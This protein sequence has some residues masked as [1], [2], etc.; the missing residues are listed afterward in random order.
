MALQVIIFF[1]VQN[2]G[3]K[4]QGTVISHQ[5]S[6]KTTC[7]NVAMEKSGSHKSRVCSGKPSKLWRDGG[8]RGTL[9]A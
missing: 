3:D 7:D 6:T 4:V 1:L 8:R 2:Q 5:M 9:E